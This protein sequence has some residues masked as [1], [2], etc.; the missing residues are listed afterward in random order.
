LVD[1]KSSIGWYGFKSDGKHD[2]VEFPPLG[3]L[4]S[5]HL[6]IPESGHAKGHIAYWE[7]E[8]YAIVKEAKAGG[9]KE[10][11]VLAGIKWGFMVNQDLKIFA[12]KRAFLGSQS[13]AFKRTVAAWN[14]QAEGPVE[15][16]FRVTQQ[17]LGPF[18]DP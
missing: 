3:N 7:F 6:D 9:L 15:S 4:D 17:T 2:D 5:N 11:Q 10:N 8:T 14:K 12:T 18:F 13:D 16:R 1:T